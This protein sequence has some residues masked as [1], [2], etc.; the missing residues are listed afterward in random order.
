M[1]HDL[2]SK[3]QNKKPFS[4]VDNPNAEFIISSISYYLNSHILL[5]LEEYQKNP[6]SILDNND[7][8]FLD[9]KNFYDETK[10]KLNASLPDSPPMSEI[11]QFIHNLYDTLNLNVEICVC[12]LI[13]IYRLSDYSNLKVLPWNWKSILLSSMILFITQK[14][15][16]ENEDEFYTHL[17]ISNVVKIFT[18]MEIK[19]KEDTFIDCIK[20]HTTIK[21]SIYLNFFVE[22]KGLLMENINDK[23]LDMN[24][25]DVHSFEANIEKISEKYEQELVKKSKTR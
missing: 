9:D 22:L 18:E 7:I 20:C 10:H 11:S 12:S 17:E 25:I 5:N 2:K 3:S 14:S 24:P 15:P 8:I 16:E 23:K 21:Y 4:P 1:D 19:L 6:A 13:F